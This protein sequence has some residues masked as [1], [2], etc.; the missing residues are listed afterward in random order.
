MFFII[1]TYSSWNVL[2]EI[3]MIYAFERY[4]QFDYFELLSKTVISTNCLGHINDWLI[5]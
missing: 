2:L 5:R 4:Y 1:N 3:F